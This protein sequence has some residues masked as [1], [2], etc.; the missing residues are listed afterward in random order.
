MPD[1]PEPVLEPVNVGWVL[2]SHGTSGE[3]RVKSYTDVPTRFD[4]G[5]DLYIGLVP[6]RITDSSSAKKDQVVLKLE[7]IEAPA[8][9]EGLSGQWLTTPAQN[10]PQLSA[11][12]FFHFQLL[13]LQARTEEGEE[14][15]TLREILQTGSNDVY[16]VEKDGREL[17]LPAISQV[18]LRVDLSAGVIVVKLLEG[19]R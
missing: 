6:Y 13:G 11:G 1:N 5:Q 15:G 4:P 8:A 17:L 3:I 18:I 10:S 14:L 19:M 12:E 9:A 2:G 16:R 7:G